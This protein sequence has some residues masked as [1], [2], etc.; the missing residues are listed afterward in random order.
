MSSAADKLR[1]LAIRLQEVQ[2]LMT[3]DTVV[4][5]HSYPGLLTDTMG[6]PTL[7]QHRPHEYEGPR[8]IASA[9]DEDEEEDEDE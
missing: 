7:K 8:G 3:E 5:P 2:N 9:E 6:G 4:D 1:K